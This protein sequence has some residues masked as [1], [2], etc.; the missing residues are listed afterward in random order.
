MN[1]ILSLLL[2]LLGFQSCSFAATITDISDANRV[3]LSS[4]SWKPSTDEASNALVAIQHFLDEGNV[5]NER[6]KGEITKILQYANEYRVQFEGR[7]LNGR[8]VIWCNF[9]RADE[10]QYKNWK[11]QKV[12]VD[13]GGFRYWQISFDPS[14]EKCEMFFSNG[15]A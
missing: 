6:N 3:I 7:K 13:D 15:Y 1:N 14:S 8:K 11:R 9:F 5:A 10:N 4:G 2:A 12:D